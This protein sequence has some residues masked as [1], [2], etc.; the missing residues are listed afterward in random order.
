MG[1]VFIIGP[2][3]PLRG[4]GIVSFN[5]RLARAF[6]ENGHPCEIWS[7][8]LQYPSFLFPGKSQ[9]TT[10]P[11]PKNLTIHSVINSINPINWIKIGLR[12]RLKRPSLVV[13]RFWIPFMGPCLGTLLRIIKRKETKIICIADN[14]IP[15]EKRPGDRLFSTY[16]FKS[17]DAFIVMSQ[18]VE[19]DL[20]KLIPRKPIQ[21]TV[22]PL[23]DHFGNSIP[24]SV[25]RE[26]LNIPLQ[27]KVILFFGFIRKYKGLDL[28]LEAMCDKRIQ[29]QHIKLII[30]GEFYE[31]EEPYTSFIKQHQLSN[32][33]R[34]KN[35]FIAD[36]QIAKY[37]CACDVVVQPYRQATQS[38]VTPLAYHF[39]KPMIVTKVGGLPEMV[40]HEKVGLVCNP[41]PKTIAD[42]IIRY[43][44]LG[45]DYFHSELVEEKKKYNWETMINTIQ[46]LAK[47][48]N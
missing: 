23:Y 21:L 40:P 35:H 41:T 9:F 17:C 6:Q 7:F 42:A 33:V 45:E 25:A 18:K 1:A 46:E 5:E 39:E 10:S 24:K 22:H 19:E 16:F 27:E 4:G 29:Q 15:H 37:L 48:I 47:K 30:A 44:E 28:L 38:G 3:H 8:S 26:K 11:A 12:I 32:A 36:D 34:I 14:A 43:Y 13:V 2:A 20:K 31:K